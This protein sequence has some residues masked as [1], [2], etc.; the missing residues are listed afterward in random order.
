M[1]EN[2]DI[3]NIN[4]INITASQHMEL[5]KRLL[6]F[7][8]SNNH[9]IAVIPCSGGNSWWEMGERSMLIYKY[10]VCNA[11]G[12][13]TTVHSDNEGFSNQYVHGYVRIRSID[14]LR[15][16]IKRAK[17]Y[18][19]EAIKDGCVFFS[20]NKIFKEYEMCDLEAKERED[21]ANSN[22]MRMVPFSDPVLYQDMVALS[23][24]VHG[25]CQRSLDTLSREINGRRITEACDEMMRRYRKMAM[26]SDTKL[27]LDEKREFWQD[28]QI[29]ID[30]VDVE[31]NIVAEVGLW[32]RAKCTSVYEQMAEVRL[33][34]AKQ[35]EKT[36]K[37]RVQEQT[38]GAEQ[39]K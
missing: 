18:G 31:L 9:Y 23:K 21:Q 6:I 7:E 3:N 2:N 13:N 24:R 16:K 30:D 1:E 39:T 27:S 20:L 12:A 22:T 28:M 5:K 38:D 33:R 14:L 25:L 19:A 29:L 15:D 17:L 4:N 10:A 35:L 11:I 26:S 37:E 36:I 34:I 8:K 32:S